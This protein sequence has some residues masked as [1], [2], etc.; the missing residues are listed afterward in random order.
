MLLVNSPNLEGKEIIE[1]FGVVT[2][3]VIMGTNLIK[4]IAACIRGLADTRNQEYEE[5]LVKA[6]KLALEE[7]ETNAT[8]LGANA[9]ISISLDFEI[10]GKGNL[11]MVCGMGT[12]VKY[13]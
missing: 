6:R 5:S 1:Y 9:V 10:M 3:E 8:N 12:A 13:Q 2:C 7:L 11:I 4:D